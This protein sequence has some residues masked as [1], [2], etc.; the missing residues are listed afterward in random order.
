MTTLLGTSSNLF[1]NVCFDVPVSQDSSINPNI[2]LAQIIDD[3]HELTTDD[4]YATYKN[5]FFNYLS[6]TATPNVARNV[7]AQNSLNQVYGGEALQNNGISPLLQIARN[8]SVILVNDNSNSNG[9]WPNG[10]EI[11]A[12]YA[13]SFNHGLTRMPF[14]PSVETFIEKGLNER[15]TF[16]GCNT[17]D[18][19]TIVYLP[20]NEYSFAS[21]KSTYQLEYPETE[22]DGM[23]ANGMEIA[24]QGGDSGWGAC[25]RCAVM[26]KTDQRLPPQ[27]HPL[28]CEI[29]LL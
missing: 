19:I 2:T 22:M 20:N 14:I 7:S 5:P 16:F 6:S 25:L 24:T 4:L 29:L 3:V 12:T 28:L 1:N 9:G 23:I 21:N 10:S 8:V 11:L 26:M 18:K 15:P 27:L 17:T 13:Q